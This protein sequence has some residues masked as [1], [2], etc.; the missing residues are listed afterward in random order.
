MLDRLTF[1]SQII[2]IVPIDHIKYSLLIRLYLLSFWN[3]S[4]QSIWA[5]LIN[6]LFKK[7][8]NVINI[9]YYSHDCYLTIIWLKHC[10]YG[11]KLFNNQLINSTINE[12]INLTS[13]NLPDKRFNLVSLTTWNDR[14][15]S[16][17]IFD[18]CHF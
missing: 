13:Q 3:V 6:V 2:S 11:V 18:Y 7:L 5:T 1:L 9:L 14:C 15:A 10:R 16:C 4:S 17:N 8:M 12:S